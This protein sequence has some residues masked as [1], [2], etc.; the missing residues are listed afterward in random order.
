MKIALIAPG[1]KPL[2]P[3]G[4]GAVESIVWDYYENLVKRNIDV[5][6]INQSNTT[7]IINECNAVP[8]DVI[9]IMYDDYIT[10]VPYINCKKILYTSHFAYITHPEF[11]HRYSHYFHGIFKKVIEFQCRIHVNTISE[12]IKNIYQKHGYYSNSIS[13]LYNGARE[14]LFRYTETPTKKDKSIYIAKIEQ[15]KGQYKYQSIPNIDFVGNFHDSSFSRENP[16]YLGEWN[17]PTLYENV[18]DYGNLVLLSDGE[19]DPLVVKEGLIAGL[20][21]VV[22]ECASANLDF[23]KEYITVIPNEKLDDILYVRE[24]IEKNREISIQQRQEIRTYALET[25]AWNTI[26]DNY[27]ENYMN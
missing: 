15:R 18:T 24:Q 9:H 4:W 22:S 17:K 25:F 1:F 6:I 13:V 8:Y 2:P 20:G 7:N 14:D 19:A 23:S 26:I 12:Q 10:V 27:L 21:V 3:Q 11:E 5:H 16:N